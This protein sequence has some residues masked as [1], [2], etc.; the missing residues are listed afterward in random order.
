MDAQRQQELWA[1]ALE[2]LQAARHAVQKKWYNVSASRS[3]YAVYTAMWLA[4]GDPSHPR[5]RHAGIAKHFTQGQWQRNQAPLPRDLRKA[6]ETLYKHRLKADYHG[7][8]VTQD[9]AQEGVATAE[10]V[11]TMVAR[12][13]VLPQH[14]LL[15]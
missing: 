7:R 10:Q 8:P 5:W 6:V 11:L 2:N 13:L 14:G 12:E 1:I 9:E 4:V 15:P 3:Y